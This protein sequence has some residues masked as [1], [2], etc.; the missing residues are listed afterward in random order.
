MAWD[1]RVEWIDGHCPRCGRNQKFGHRDTCSALAL[2]KRRDKDPERFSA[3]AVQERQERRQREARAMPGIPVTSGPLGLGADQQQ[4]YD[5][6]MAGE[7]VLIG[8]PAGTGKSHL[9]EQLVRDLRA[10]HREVAVTA[11]TGIAALNIGG[12]TIHSFLGTAQRRSIGDVERNMPN[13]N[14]WVTGRLR[15]VQALIVDEVS[16]LTGDYIDMMNSWV[17]YIRGVPHRAGATPFSRVQLILCGDFLQLP[18]VQTG[19]EDPAENLY[20]F[21]A[22]CWDDLKVRPFLLRENFRQADRE[23]TYHLLEMREGRVSQETRDFF[24]PCVGRPLDEP[25]RL[26][27]H[28]ETAQKINLGKLAQLPG[29]PVEFEAEFTGNAKLYPVL[30]KHC[31]AEERLVLKP[32]APVIFI[33]NEPEIGIVNGM[34]GRVLE[35]DDVEDV[36]YAKRDSDGME[37]VLSRSQWD[38]CNEQGKVLASMRQFPVKLAW[39]LTIHK[40]Q[41]MT[42]DNVKCDLERVFECGHAYVALSR[43]RTVA[44]LALEGPVRT[45]QFRASDDAMMFYEDLDAD[46]HEQQEQPEQQP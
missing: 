12:G 17:G 13:I 22:K 39:A 8:G 41:G 4:V 26:V 19:H 15:G 7:N 23:F 34:R 16:M 2:M 24:A 25:T 45:E 14:S 31:I 36:I 20:A 1:P 46:L 42:L 38:S 5:A 44:G 21:D 30:Q 11:S 9:L 40:S 28:N 32:G 6:V 18:P 37:I 29:A 33:K 35:V 10:K 27:P 3:D 43:A